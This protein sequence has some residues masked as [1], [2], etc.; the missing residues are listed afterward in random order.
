MLTKFLFLGEGCGLFF[1]RGGG[2]S[3]DFNF[4]GVGIFSELEYGTSLATPTSSSLVNSDLPYP[5][6]WPVP[7]PWSET[8]VSIPL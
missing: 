2:G 8:M 1:W 7:R 3:A 4:L 6:V 5:M